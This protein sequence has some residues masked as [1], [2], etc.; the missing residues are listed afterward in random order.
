MAGR[1]LL[2]AQAR[3]PVALRSCPG[4]SPA[5][6]PLR[7]AAS[8][9]LATFLFAWCLGG[10]FQPFLAVGLENKCPFLGT[11]QSLLTPASSLPGAGL[12]GPSPPAPPW[13][14]LGAAAPEKTASQSRCPMPP[15]SPNRVL[16]GRP[17]LP[18]CG[19]V[20]SPS[21]ASSPRSSGGV[22]RCAWTLPMAGASLP[23]G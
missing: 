9:A 22:S 17:G 3:T 15:P 19:D 12:A 20:P 7:V 21:C 14:A 16:A 10:C 18:L 1:G 2:C 4:S 23:E 6:L 5:R 8:G 11:A 13:P